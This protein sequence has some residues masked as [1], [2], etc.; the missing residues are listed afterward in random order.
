MGS[1]L[2]PFLLIVDNFERSVEEAD[3]ALPPNLGGSSVLAHFEAQI[4][5]SLQ[6]V[7]SFENFLYL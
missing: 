3:F 4:F 6:V 5:A 7:H 2:I 1:R